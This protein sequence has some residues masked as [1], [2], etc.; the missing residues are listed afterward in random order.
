VHNRQTH[1]DL[2]KLLASQLI[3]LHHFAAYGPIGDGL[4]L[5]SP[6]LISWLY[7]DARMAVQVFLVLAGYLA[8]RSLTA[9]GQQNL[10]WSLPRMV[11]RRYVRLIA[12]FLVALALAIGCAAVARLGMP[13]SQFVPETPSWDQLLAHALLL[14]GVLGEESISAGVW[15]VAIDFQLFTLMATLVWL[16]SKAMVVRKMAQLLV[17]STM[18]ASLYVF[19]RNEGLDNWAIYF[20]GSYGLGAATFWASRSRS[21]RGWLA[22]VIASTTLALL[23]DFRERIALALG[24]SVILGCIRW[25]WDHWPALPIRLVRLIARLGQSSYALF[26]VHFSVLMLT[27]TLFEVLD[28]Q[29]TWSAVCMLLGSMAAATA[30]ALAFHRW[31]EVPLSHRF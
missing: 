5:A 10:P 11:V 20:F 30:L 17:V 27:N 13:H 3:V 7:N 26:L 23:V 16:G 28:L 1:I 2:L 12:P 24:V 15:Y 8:A 9:L 18:L 31:V 22:I 6:G 25:Q 21:S 4:G 14:H 29:G 19:N